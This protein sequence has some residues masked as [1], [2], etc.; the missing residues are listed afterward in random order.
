MGIAVNSPTSVYAVLT[1]DAFCTAPNHLNPVELTMELREEETNMTPRGDQLL[2][3]TFLFHE[4]RL[5][6]EDAPGATVPTVSIHRTLKPSLA[7]IFAS[8]A[9]S[10]QLCPPQA[11]IT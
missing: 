5:K 3:T 4:V 10:F 8:G 7:F 1:D 6:F 2:K 9:V 11:S